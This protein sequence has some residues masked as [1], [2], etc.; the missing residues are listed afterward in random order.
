[1]LLRPVVANLDDPLF[2]QC[3]RDHW[4]RTQKVEWNTFFRTFHTQSSS[5]S[6]KIEYKQ[7]FVAL[8][9]ILKPAVIDEGRMYAHERQ[10]ALQIPSRRVS[11]TG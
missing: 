8:C 10:G 4:L 2:L 9:R 11:S 6:V 7:E 3:G 1:M 5:S